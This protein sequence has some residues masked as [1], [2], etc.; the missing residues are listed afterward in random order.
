MKKTKRSIQNNAIIVSLL[1]I[2]KSDYFGN[3]NEKNINNNKTFWKTIKL[4]LSDKVSLK[5]LMT[6]IDKEEIIMGDCNTATFLNTFFSNIVSNLNIP[7]YSNLLLT[8][9]AI[10]F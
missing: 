7:E 9:S 8:V 3:L 4:F 6:L 10:L 1:R 5:N 2:S